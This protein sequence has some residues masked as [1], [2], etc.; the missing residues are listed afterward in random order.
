MKTSILT[1]IEVPPAVA[2]FMEAHAEAAV[3]AIIDYVDR[4]KSIDDKL[5]ALGVLAQVLIAYGDSL[6][7]VQLTKIK[8]P[9]A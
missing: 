6:Q 4:C 8:A 7:A 1:K 5:G 2:P 9:M 3:K